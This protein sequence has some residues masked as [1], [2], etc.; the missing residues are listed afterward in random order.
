VETNIH[1]RALFGNIDLLIP[2]GVEVELRAVTQVG[3]TKVEA[4]SGTPGAP[5]IVLTG[6]TFFGDVKVRHRRLW[7][8]LARRDRP[9]G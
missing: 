5:R 4:G 3:R 2:E 1:A 8:K 7:D 6:G 9:T